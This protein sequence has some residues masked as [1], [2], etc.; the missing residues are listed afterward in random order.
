MRLS[1]FGLGVGFAFKDILSNLL[2]GVIVLMQGRFHIGDFIKIG[3]NKGK[4]VEIQ[5]RSTILKALD[6]TEIIIPNADFLSKTVTS[7]TTNPTRRVEVE[8]GVHYNTDLELATQ[9][10]E[11]VVRKNENVLPAPKS[12][13]IAKSFA[14]SAII[15]A[16]RFW[17]QTR[18]GTSW[19]IVKSQVDGTSWI[20]VKSQVVHSIKKAFEEHGITIPFPI[21]TVHQGAPEDGLEWQNKPHEAP[22]QPEAEKA[23]ET[24]PSEPET[25]AEEPASQTPPQTEG[26][27]A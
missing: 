14:D 17:V 15:L 26:A 6:G 7:Y 27:E 22:E 5:T 13:V 19:I 11:D 1:S 16:V 12:K 23:P 21:R 8:V 24:A 4:V 25:V 18:D 10:I 2:A 9:I 3:E 20:I